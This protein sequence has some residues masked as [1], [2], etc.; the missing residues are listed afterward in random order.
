MKKIVR[1]LE[2]R[3][4]EKLGNYA[5]R[6]AIYLFDLACT[7]VMF[8]LLWV[9]RDLVLE[10]RQP[11]FMC[12]LGLALLTYAGTSYLF[13]TFHGV[14]R[15][16]SARDLGKLFCAC[17]SGSFAWLVISAAGA[18]IIN[19]P[20]FFSFWFPLIVATVMFLTLL[21]VRLI[22][23]IVYESYEQNETANRTNVFVLYSGPEAV[24]LATYLVKNIASGYKPVAFLPV[25]PGLAGNTIAGL[26]ILAPDNGVKVFAQKNNVTSIVMF[27]EQLDKLPKNFYEQF[28]TDGYE[29]LKVS[30]VLDSGKE[31]QVMG[32]PR[33]DKIN[34][35]DLL[36]RNT[37]VLDKDRIK[38][39][40]ED[41]TVLITGAA[42]SIGAEIARQ[43]TRHF[44]C[45]EVILLDQA[46]TPLN[47]L[48]LELQGEKVLVPVKP[49]IANVA[50]PVKMRQVFDIARP[51]IVFHAAA[52]KHVPM[53]EFHPSAAV[54]TNLGGTKIL[55]DLSIEYGVKRFVM[56]STDKAVNPTN[57]MGA[58]KR[59]AEIYIQS[60]FLEQL[61]NGAKN[62]T[63]F[64]TTRFGNVLGSN[65]SVVPLFKR[66]I[67]R[68]GPVT[69]TH[70]N[71][72]RYFMTIPEA[73]SLVLE[74]GCTGQGGEIYLFNMGDTVRIYDLAEKMIR[75]AGKEPHKDIKILEIGL[76][77]GEKLYEELL[78]KTEETRPTYNS[79]ILIANVRPYD[80]REIQPQIE[81]L[82]TQ[83]NLYVYP[84]EVVRKLKK[85][86]PEFK[87]QNSK[88]AQLD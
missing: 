41:Q 59:A 38:D 57:V 10:E 3:L 29:L 15:F 62:T 46:E 19:D 8:S 47:D 39:T 68:G 2:H 49:I 55:A 22:V 61:R 73:C 66:Q 34:I 42:G 77:E 81:D 13:K 14:L 75:M 1:N 51:N 67:A 76:R 37:I 27:A 35:D 17:T 71:V 53:M 33:I 79:N 50:N 52:Y 23:R 88:Y 48:W 65:G 82:V 72:I 54:A 36:G 20:R 31:T 4:R 16:S 70:R 7:A 18:L 26:P 69:V 85:L 78:A 11:F 87:S 60:L 84:I 9:L 44:R 83:A 32:A 25:D 74:A 43:I 30:M 5:P 64:V 21:T 58:S 28:M 6:W 12:H 45:R 40:F 56:I 63:Q 24:T 86:I 80:Y